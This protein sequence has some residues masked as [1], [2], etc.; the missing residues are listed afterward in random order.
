MKIELTQ[1]EKWTLAAIK[2]AYR[3]QKM[4]RV[5]SIDTDLANL[6][7]AAAKLG[8]ELRKRKKKWGRKFT[9]VVTEDEL[10]LYMED[11]NKELK[12]VGYCKV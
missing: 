3:T 11:D 6:E 10:E 1:N 7:L 2:S 9:A 5:R 12:L 4:G 8:T